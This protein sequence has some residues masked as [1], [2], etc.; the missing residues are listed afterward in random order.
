M[1]CVYVCFIFKDLSSLRKKKCAGEIVYHKIS[2]S[3]PVFSCGR[4]IGQAVTD[5]SMS[6][7]RNKMKTDGSPG[8]AHLYL[9]SRGQQDQRKWEEVGQHR[10][11]EDF[12]EDS[13]QA[14]GLETE[15]LPY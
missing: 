12:E 11:T 6:I 1:W 7:K 13:R 5:T 8:S 4:K 14:N 10:P 9:Q 3:I 15:Q 2:I